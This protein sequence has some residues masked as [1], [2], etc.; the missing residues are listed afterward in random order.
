MPGYPRSVISPGCPHRRSTG[1]AVTSEESMVKITALVAAGLIVGLLVYA[2][3]KPD[4]FSVQRSMDIKA[5]SEKIFTLI[6]DLQ[7]WAAWSPWEKMDPIMKR[8]YSGAARGKGAVYEWEGNRDVGKG[9]MEITD[10]S[11]PSKVVIKLDF[12]T[13]FEAHNTA[14]FTLGP[15]GDFTNVTWA[16]YGPNPYMSKVMTVF[17]D[18]DSM[19]GKQFETG[20]AN[21]KA[22]AEN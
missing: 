20:L 11:S 17:F 9:R 7:N 16:M 5:P 6:D 8:T 1:F 19:I 14:E 2:G 21:L 10:T 4:A 22:I 18:M 15:A 3:T 13:P 12:I